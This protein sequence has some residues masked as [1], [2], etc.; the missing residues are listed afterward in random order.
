MLF[1][2]ATGTSHSWARV[3]DKGSS[4]LDGIWR[5]SRGHIAIYGETCVTGAQV[6]TIQCDS[7]WTVAMG[8][9]WHFNLQSFLFDS[10]DWAPKLDTTILKRNARK[11][12]NG[13]NIHWTRHSAVGISQGCHRDAYGILVHFRMLTLHALK[14]LRVI[15]ILLLHQIGRGGRKWERRNSQTFSDTRDSQALLEQRPLILQNYDHAYACEA[16]LQS[17]MDSGAFNVDRSISDILIRELEYI[18]DA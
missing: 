9:D 6:W 14:E 15:D 8:D 16:Y 1:D 11:R 12:N 18:M 4:S 2:P 3:S 10:A 7:T 17:R 5:T 13:G